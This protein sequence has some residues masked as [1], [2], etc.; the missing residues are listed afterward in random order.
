MKYKVTY[1]VYR[2]HI[3]W[4]NSFIEKDLSIYLDMKQEYLEAK[5]YESDKWP[6]RNLTYK[7][8]TK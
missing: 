8:I 3:W 1:E 2:F 5:A 7:L 4:K 6:I